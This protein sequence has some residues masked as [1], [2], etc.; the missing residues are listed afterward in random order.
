[1]ILSPILGPYFLSQL[2]QYTLFLGLE[3]YP[4]TSVPKTCNLTAMRQT[5][6]LS[7][8]PLIASRNGPYVSVKFPVNYQSFSPSC[9]STGRIWDSGHPE[10]GLSQC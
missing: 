4:G 7:G 9:P 10:T 5:F 2:G 6:F 8:F 1:M 3:T